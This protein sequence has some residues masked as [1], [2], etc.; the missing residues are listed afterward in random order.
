MYFILTILSFFFLRSEEALWL[1]EDEVMRYTACGASLMKVM[2][3]KRAC[4]SHLS[5]EAT[6]L[7]EVMHYRLRCCE[8]R[9]VMNTRLKYQERDKEREKERE[10]KRSYS[11]LGPESLL[12]L[13]FAHQQQTEGL[14]SALYLLR[15]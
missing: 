8:F 13:G 11:C 12:F 9:P 14:I 6:S 2:T 1:G 7:T 5:R 4:H 15:F 3:V 10:T